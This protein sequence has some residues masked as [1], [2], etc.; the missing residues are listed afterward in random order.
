M[1]RLPLVIMKGLKDYV[2]GHRPAPKIAL[3]LGI[4]IFKIFFL[5]TISY[6]LK[7]SVNLLANRTSLYNNIAQRAQL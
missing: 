1:C 7:A 3:I 4:I 6:L 2:R 5:R